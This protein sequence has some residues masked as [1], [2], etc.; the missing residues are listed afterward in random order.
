VLLILLNKKPATLPIG[1]TEGFS[2]NL[3]TPDKRKG[4]EVGPFRLLAMDAV[5][6]EIVSLI[7]PD[8][9]KNTGNF[10]HFQANS[11]LSRLQLTVIPVI[12]SS[13]RRILEYQCCP[14]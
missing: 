8:I 9:G 5:C 11:S 3:H 14:T 4:P 7:F 13:F 2:S 10:H 6:C 12:L 1:R